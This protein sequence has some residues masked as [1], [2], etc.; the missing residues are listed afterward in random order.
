[1]V[2][3]VPNAVMMQR[4]QVASYQRCFT[5]TSRS[6]DPN[7]RVSAGIIKQPENPFTFESRGQS[8][9]ANF[10]NRF[11]RF[12]HCVLIGGIESSILSS[13]MVSRRDI[14]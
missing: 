5:G 10:V 13:A 9:T 2:D 1:M 6:G 12:A 14:N 7:D 8:G 3:L 11:D 4:F